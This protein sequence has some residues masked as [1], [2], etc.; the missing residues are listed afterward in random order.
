MGP[1][2]IIPY[3][4]TYVGGVKLLRRGESE[5][6]PQLIKKPFGRLGSDRASVGTSLD[7]YQRENELP[8]KFHVNWERFE[9]TIYSRLG[10]FSRCLIHEPL[11]RA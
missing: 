7:Y 5:S 8:E 6:D 1:S 11:Y 3:E 4:L 10:M 2:S 9:S